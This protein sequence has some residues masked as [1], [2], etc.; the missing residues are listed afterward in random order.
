M[1]KK[2]RGF[3]NSIWRLF[4]LN[5]SLGY[6]AQS[7]SRPTNDGGQQSVPK[8]IFWQISPSDGTRRSTNYYPNFLLGFLLSFDSSSREF[9][10]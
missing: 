2:T 6:Y 3:K 7:R 5:S 8:V 10:R 1:K 4:C 9:I